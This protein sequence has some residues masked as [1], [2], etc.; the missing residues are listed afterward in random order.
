MVDVYDK[1]VNRSAVISATVF[2]GQVRVGMCESRG[3][4]EL[5]ADADSA[6]AMGR[7]LREA[8]SRERMRNRPECPEPPRGRRIVKV[9]MMHDP[10][11]DG[12]ALG[13][14]S[15]SAQGVGIC[16]DTFD[17]EGIAE[18]FEFWLSPEDADR[19]ADALSEAASRLRQAKPES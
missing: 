15:V 13:I 6:S 3:D 17:E 5:F 14:V 9:V 4:M 8:A 12:D 1:G 16:L 18:T 11:V 19:A 10:D 7:A 2:S